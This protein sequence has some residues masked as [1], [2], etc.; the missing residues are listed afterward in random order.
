M[1][2]HLSVITSAAERAADQRGKQMLRYFS[3]QKNNYKMP[4]RCFSAFLHILE[5]TRED[6]TAPATTGCASS[7]GQR[8]P[9]RCKCGAELHGALKRKGASNAHRIDCCVQRKQNRRITGER[10][11]QDAPPSSCAR[12][13][14]SGSTSA[15][16]VT[17]STKQND[18]DT[19]PTSSSN[20]VLVPF[21]LHLQPS[22]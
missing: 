3:F 19:H 1:Q 8:G 16:A 5:L 14:E 22:G 4:K 18:V 20:R 6:L 2:R 12:R 11:R 21:P 9:F 15:A 13:V 10:L 7:V 17:L